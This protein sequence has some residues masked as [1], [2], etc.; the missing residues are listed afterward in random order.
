MK[1]SDKVNAFFIYYFLLVVTEAVEN[2]NVLLI[3]SIKNTPDIGNN[4][5]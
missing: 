4:F 3:T 2:S 1:Q 5:T